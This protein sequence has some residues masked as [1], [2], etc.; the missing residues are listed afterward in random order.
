MAKGIKNFLKKRFFLNPTGEG[1]AAASARVS[2]NFRIEPRNFT[3]YPGLDVD[4]NISI[5]DCN[6]QI[7]LEFDIWLH[8]DRREVRKELREKRKKLARLKQIVDEFVEATSK[9]YDFVEENLD[10]YFEQYKR[11][12]DAKK[13]QP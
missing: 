1:V 13:K 3:K 11:V 9:A 12:E 2:T 7:C 6:R 5:S 4:A 8:G 10:E